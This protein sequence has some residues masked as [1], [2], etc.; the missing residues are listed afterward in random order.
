M[1]LQ[2]EG[3]RC[4]ALGGKDWDA[5]TEHGADRLCLALEVNE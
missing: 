5:Y 4:L 3:F 2:K 1:L